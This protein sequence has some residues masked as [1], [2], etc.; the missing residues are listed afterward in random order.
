MVAEKKP[1]DAWRGTV[2]A[3]SQWKR[4]LR[5]E[6]DCNLPVVLV[7]IV[8]MVD[9]FLAGQPEHR[10]ARS[11]L[12]KYSNPTNTE[13]AANCFDAGKW[14]GKVGIVDLKRGLEIH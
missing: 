8:E 13:G 7:P 11:K 14:G 10:Y 4:R 1:N 6:T 5:N 12:M 3:F 2:H 9:A